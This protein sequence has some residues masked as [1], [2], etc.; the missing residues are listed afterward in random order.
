MPAVLPGADLAKEIPPDEIEHHRIGLES[1]HLAVRQRD[2]AGLG[3][4]VRQV[5]VPAAGIELELQGRVA[6]PPQ[7]DVVHPLLEGRELGW[8]KD[9]SQS[10]IALLFELPPLIIR[11]KIRHDVC[12]SLQERWPGARGR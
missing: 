1:L 7:H 5:F 2:S 8:V 10:Q 4:G 9:R 11:E 6:N 3:V 12:S